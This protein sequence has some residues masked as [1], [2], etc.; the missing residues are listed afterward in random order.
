MPS[1]SL[2]AEIAWL[3]ASVVLLLVYIGAQCGPDDPRPRARIQRRAPA[4]SSRSR[5]ASWR[6]APSGRSPISWKPIR[7]S[8]LWPLALAVTGRS[9]GAGAIGAAVWFWARV[10]YLPLYLFGIPYVRTAVWS[11]SALGLGGMLYRLFFF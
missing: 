2:P 7:P 6:A 9:G 4:T 8:S 3:G 5:R 11:V 1:A 10:V